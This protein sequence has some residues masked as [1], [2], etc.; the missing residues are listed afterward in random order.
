LYEF[1][2]SAMRTT[3]PAH[4]ILPDLITVTVFGAVCVAC[5]YLG[6]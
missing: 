6:M 1:L 2:I 4:L 3:C 5:L